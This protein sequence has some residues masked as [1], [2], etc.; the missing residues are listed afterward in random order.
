MRKRLL[1]ML[2]A[3]VFTFSSVDMAAYATNNSPVLAK[4]E[5]HETGSVEAA[6]SG[7][8]SVMPS[9]ISTGNGT[10]ETDKG[11]ITWTIDQSGV[12][13]VEGKGNIANDNIDGTLI[14][15]SGK[16]FTSAV[17]KLEE[18]TDLSYFFADCKNLRSVDF[19]GTDTGF[20][21]DMSYMFNDCWELHEVDLSAFDTADVENMQGMFSGCKNLRT[22]IWDRNKFDT[23][24]VTNMNSM[25]MGCIHL[26]S[27]DFSG[28]NTSNV[29]DMSSMFRGCAKL[30]NLDLGSFDT[31]R[32]TNMANMFWE[33]TGL[34]NL[35]LGRFNTENVTNMSEMFQGCS[36]LANLNVSGFNTAKVTDMSNMFAGCTDLK[37][38]DLSSFDMGNV[39]SVGT[40]LG[41][42]DFWDNDNTTLEKIRSP[43]NLSQTVSLPA[44]PGETWYTLNG[45]SVT[46]LPKESADSVVIQKNKQPEAG[47]TVNVSDTSKRPVF[48]IT[49][50]VNPDLKSFS[51]KI[52]GE[53]VLGT[54]GWQTFYDSTTR[55]VTWQPIK[56]LEEGNHELVLE[57]EDNNGNKLGTPVIKSFTVVV[58]PPADPGPGG[59]EPGGDGPG[60]DVSGG[61]GPGA[62]VSGNEIINKVIVV[63]NE[64]YIR[65]RAWSPYDRL[66]KIEADI[67]EKYADGDVSGNGV[68]G[69]GTIYSMDKGKGYFTT[70]IPVK[71][72]NLQEVR[73]TVTGSLGEITDSYDTIVVKVQPA[74]K[75][76]DSKVQNDLW[77]KFVDD[78]GNEV[79][80]EYIYTGKNITPQIEV[81]EG[82]R[83]LIPK[84]DY[85][86]SYKNNKNAGTAVAVVK[87]KGLYTKQAEAQF[88]ILPKNLDNAEDIYETLSD[89]TVETM[90]AVQKNKQQKLVPTIKY[91]KTKLKNNKDFTVTYPSNEAGAYQSAGKWE[92]KVT[93]TGNYTGE[94]TLDFFIGEKLAKKLKVDKIAKQNYSGEAIEPQ[95]TVKDGKTLL[96]IENGDYRIEYRNNVNAGTAQAVVICEG[97][98]YVGEKVVNFTIQ[99]T[100]ISKAAGKLAAVEYNGE[101]R[102]PVIGSLVEGV[103]YTATYKNNLFAGTAT[104]ELT[105]IGKYSGTA[106]KTFKINPFDAVSNK[107]Q[108]IAFEVSESAAY[109]KGGAK[110]E[111]SLYF[112]DQELMEGID[113]KLSHKNNKKTG[114][115]TVAIK[116]QKNF[117]G[118]VSKSYTIE[119]QDISNLISMTQDVAISNKKNFWKSKVVV[120]D[121]DGKKLAQ[122]KD[123]EKVVTYYTDEACTTAATAETYP[124]G[125][126]IFVKVVGKGGYKGEMIQSFKIMNQVISKAKVKIDKQEYTGEP[127]VLD[128]DDITQVKV[129]QNILQGGRDYIIDEDSYRNNLKK[130]KAEVTLVGTGDYGGSITVKYTI[131]SKN[132]IWRAL[133]ELLTLFQ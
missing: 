81:Y 60:G 55:K 41:G 73:V 71:D 42:K 28:F 88:T 91:G 113:Y 24:N 34:V 50:D 111:L 126:E 101:Y 35:N 6:R 89:I 116:F 115:A 79:S 36:D 13:T 5:Y 20:V 93:G 109:A 97:P 122:N 65:V 43:R 92:V 102:K 74:S 124:V 130:G 83:L 127:V 56:D 119:Q 9:V 26:I 62:D 112:G 47:V 66:D 128:Y 58:V 51:L 15:W 57:V 1:S 64:N 48:T 37:E 22:I 61:D 107:E 2:L 100:P 7:A 40:Y 53:E 45:D 76:D 90:A 12:L 133:E 87:G 106:K 98:K 39:S 18:V 68:S 114:S 4:T 44:A 105:G 104:V 17:V 16:N 77:V 95:V 25:F 129:G 67:V 29:T 8:S 82:V 99:G 108:M 80:N 110:P 59:E 11:E 103:D 72:D 94:L 86:V 120:V 132:F 38:L 63:V 78:E 32:V 131:T 75:V 85:T 54:E 46:E 14:P 21:T 96:T 19:T 123:Y 23:S 121:L 70:I 30:V 69:N 31:S 52:D 118:T 3:A 125:T 84:T 49:F 10:I 33:C 27:V 117:K